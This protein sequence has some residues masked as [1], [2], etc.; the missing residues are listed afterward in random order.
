MFQSYCRQ[1]A[2]L[3]ASSDGS[4]VIVPVVSSVVV[5]VFVSIAIVSIFLYKRRRYK[6]Y[7][8]Q[9]HHQKIMSGRVINRFHI[10]LTIFP[11]QGPIL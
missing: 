9:K 10:K 2:T 3:D 1:N 6:T 8:V 4:N 7:D 5:I 11:G